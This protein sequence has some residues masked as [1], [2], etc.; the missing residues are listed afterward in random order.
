M[1]FKFRST[2]MLGML[3][4][5]AGV[6]A[7]TAGVFTV[8]LDGSARRDTAEELTR[9]RRVFEDL[10]A[11]RQSLLRAEGRVVSE[12]PR[13]KAVIA[14][15]SISHETVVGVAN[16]LRQTLQ[17]DVFVLTDE[18]AQLVVD[19]ANPK[20]EDGDLS[21]NKLIAD[22]LKEGEAS[23]VW[24]EGDR[25]YQMQARRLA[26]GDTVV[27]V[28]ATGYR[29]DDRVAQTVE[30]QTA[31][32]VFVLLDGKLV[33]GSGLQPNAQGI[34][35]AGAARVLDGVPMG[36]GV[37]EIRLEDVTYIASRA[38]L[39]GYQG[40][41][42]ASYVV[43]RSLDR[44]LAPGRH[45]IRLLYLIMA[46]AA[47]ASIAI[48]AL[49]ARRLAR[50]LDDLVGF[51]RRIAGG[52]TTPATVSGP[53]EIQALSTAMNNMVSELTASRKEAGKK[54]RL[55][56]EMEIAAQ[57][58]TS[59]LP[60]KLEAVG[61][62]L[63]GRMVTASEV[64]GDYYDVIPTKDGC[65]VGIGDVAGHGLTAGLVMM[66]LQS[67]VSGLCRAVES[68]TPARAVTL[69]NEV[70]YDNLRN[71]LE[72]RVHITLTLLRFE[73]NGRVVFAGAHEEMVLLRKGAEKCEMI[74]TPGTWVGG[75]QDVSAVTTNSELQLG[76][77]DLL[78]L[79]TDGVTEARDAKRAQFGLE[80]LCAEVERSRTEPV[81][82]IRDR[83]LSAVEKW[84]VDRDDDLTIVV[85]RHRATTTT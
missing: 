18:K 31:S 83:L 37:A 13:L 40:K 85:L 48:S 76:E 63:A 39:P 27:G 25:V 71:R 77:G 80:G 16:E 61:L 73:S 24:T 64:G 82:D 1:N 49:L 35:L 19:V 67:V 9:T 43:V 50:P 68:L 51:T 75:M 42:H 84:T 62:E 58:Q 54:D 26:F 21:T 56:K 20:A 81:A 15:D 78:V 69:A 17:T 45:L 34:D 66:M 41:G 52:A 36:D 59:I 65:W 33:A 8:V 60:R 2:V 4:V 23:G 70:L 12:E 11:Y 7:A 6:L 5:L 74:E 28:L 57:I 22:A 30:A 46:I 72:S 47:A 44:A 10:H 32:G 3:A 14:T 29:W 53:P 79:Y 38:P 55:E